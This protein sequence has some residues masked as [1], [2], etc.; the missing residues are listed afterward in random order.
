MRPLKLMIILNIPVWQKKVAVWYLFI[1]Y[2]WSGAKEK[3]EHIEKVEISLSEMRQFCIRRAF[4]A[5]L[6]DSKVLILSLCSSLSELY[7]QTVLFISNCWYCL[8][9]ISMLSWLLQLKNIT[10]IIV[11]I[12]TK[13]NL[14]IYPYFYCFFA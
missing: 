10:K 14:E 12:F 7:Q 6:S 9:S 5:G 8:C 3:K 2:L 4:K 13:S 1:Q 11:L